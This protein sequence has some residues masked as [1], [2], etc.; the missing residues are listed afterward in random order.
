MG[1]KITLQCFEV[2]VRALTVY[3]A[4]LHELAR[5]VIDEQLAAYRA[6]RDPQ[7]SDARCH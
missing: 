3:K 1:F 4:Q 2:G 7:T 6:H 5:C